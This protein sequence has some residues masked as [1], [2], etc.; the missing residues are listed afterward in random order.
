MQADEQV[1]VGVGLLGAAGAR[2]DRD[3]HVVRFDPPCP[4][5]IAITNGGLIEETRSTAAAGAAR[6]AVGGRRPQPS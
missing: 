5:S 3:H 1:G 6:A 2:L 4:A